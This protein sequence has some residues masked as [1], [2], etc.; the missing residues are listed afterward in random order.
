MKKLLAVIL[1]LCMLMPCAVAEDVTA[2]SDDAL[3]ALYIAVKE[4]LMAR[5]LWDS[6]IL[7]AGVYVAGESLPEGYYELTLNDNA[8]VAA[9]KSYEDFKQSD[10]NNADDTVFYEFLNKGSKLTMS[11]IDGMCWRIP[12]DAVVRPFTGLVW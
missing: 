12:C 5:K 9:W 6:S 3:K 8:I 2:M 1:L 7:P 11:L 4:E 10:I